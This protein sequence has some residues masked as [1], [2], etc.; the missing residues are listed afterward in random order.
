M[1]ARVQGAKGGAGNGFANYPLYA[2][3]KNATTYARDFTD[4][5]LGSKRPLRRRYRL[6]L[7]HWLG[8]TQGLSG[9]I[10]DIAGKC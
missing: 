9:L 7:H 2:M 3:G 1:W 4:I 5:T 6:G 8:R 10:C